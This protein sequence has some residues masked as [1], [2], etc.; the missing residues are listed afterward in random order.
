MK[1]VSEVMKIKEEIDNISIE[2]A[3]QKLDDSNVQF[4]DVRDKATFDK[5]TIGNAINLER[6][7]LEFYLA[8]GSP[9]Q[10][11]EF[12]EPTDKEYIVLCNLGG[13][14][15]LSSK[16]MKDMGIRNV[17]NLVGGYTEWQKKFG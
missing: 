3:H 16:T 8:D 1:H 2:D 17:K 12:K 5:G 6:G 10:V 7:L 15:A 4:V 9:L 13:Q 14:S 11:D